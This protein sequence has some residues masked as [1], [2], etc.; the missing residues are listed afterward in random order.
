MRGMRR[1]VVGLAS[2]LLMVALLVVPIAASAH[3]HRDPGAARNCATCV[4]AHHSPAIVMPAI[5]AAASPC[6]TL[7]L[8]LPSRVAPAHPHRS[9]RAGRAPPAP[10]PVSVS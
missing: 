8:P 3:T 10:V 4:A 1:R 9:P 2:A 7:A 5:Q 6:A